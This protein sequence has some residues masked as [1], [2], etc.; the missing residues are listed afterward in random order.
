SSQAGRLSNAPLW[1]EMEDFLT[2]KICYDLYTVPKILPCLHS[3]CQHCLEP[4]VRDRALQCPE[5]RLQTD[6]PGGASSLK[7]NFFINSLLEL[8]QIKHNRD[9]ACTVCSDAQKILTAAARCLDCKDF[10][11]QSCTQ[12]SFCLNG[13]SLQAIQIALYDCHVI[14]YHFTDFCVIHKFYLQ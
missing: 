13:P 3:Y 2:C 7:T 6:V 14:I 8:F 10:L 9:L 1:L 5:C 11:C 12:E 4:L